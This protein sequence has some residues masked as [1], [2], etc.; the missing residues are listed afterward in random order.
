MKNKIL[1]VLT[2]ISVAYGAAY[3]SLN[4]RDPLLIWNWSKIDTSKINFP[5]E[6][7]W[8]AASAA[9][10]VEGGHQ[11]INNFGRWEKQFHE[12]LDIL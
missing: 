5:K 11:D 2:L 7:V 12:I 4:S 6:F 8:G 3:W 1:V 10:Q 9:H